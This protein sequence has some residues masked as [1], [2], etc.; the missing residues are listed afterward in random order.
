MY[1][2]ADSRLER[3]A[4]QITLHHH[5]RWDGSG[6]NGDLDIPPLSGEDIP[7]PARITSVADVLDAL[8]FPRRY[9]KAWKF[10]DAMSELE[11]NSGSQ[12]DPDVIK[13]TLEISNTLKTII[14][15]FR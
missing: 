4:Y 9:K 15:E 12:F 10:E 11:R 14:E 5:E 6:Y 2:S 3:M 8:V 1:A 7:L 13:A